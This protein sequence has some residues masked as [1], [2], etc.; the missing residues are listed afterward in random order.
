M[1]IPYAAVWKM[2]GVIDMKVELAIA[3]L[4]CFMLALGHTLIG[5]RWVLPH[6]NDERL[7]RTPF[8]SLAMTVG[9]LRFTWIIVSVLLWGF[10]ILFMMLA[11]A[12]DADPKRL[13]LRW[14]AALWLVATVTAL[15]NA[16]RRLRSVLRLPVPFVTVLIA[17]MCWRASG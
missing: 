2:A 8:G 5:A 15:W 6:L 9:M 16:R 13:L 4:S 11:W 12:P 1:V 7:P 10:S 3:G 17:V 14:F